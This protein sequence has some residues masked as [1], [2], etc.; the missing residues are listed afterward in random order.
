MGAETL[1]GGR[2]GR[3][4]RVFAFLQEVRAE[5]GK[6]TWPTWPELKKATSVIVVVVLV[7]GLAIGWLD[8]FLQFVL[9]K[10]VARLF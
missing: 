8:V 1:A 4:A 3:I 7:L 10:L 6:V 9:V 2:P 5:I